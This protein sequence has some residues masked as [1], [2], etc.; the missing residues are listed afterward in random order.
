MNK[1]AR[2]N[3]RP[4]TVSEIREEIDLSRR[5]L[6]SSADSLRD[7]LL[8]GV[9]EIRQKAEEIKEKL[10]WKNWVARHPWKFVAGAVA[11]GIILGRKK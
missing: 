8:E 10:Y 3:S 7:D 2:V 6:A 5:R 11:V 1:L 9:R 4:Q